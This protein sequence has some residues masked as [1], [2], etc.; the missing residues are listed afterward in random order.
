MN[1]DKTIEKAVKIAIK[2]YDKEK[3]SIEMKKVFHNT[4]LLMKHYNDLKLHIDN[5]VSDLHEIDQDI[6]APMDYYEDDEL[7]ILSIRKSKIKTLIMIS[8]IDAALDVLYKNE[9]R[10]GTVEKYLA[11]KK[12]FVDKKTYECIAEELNCS[13]ITVRRWV[14]EMLKQLGIYL[15]GVES[16]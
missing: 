6:L 3:K 15:F 4:K 10:N 2:E 8:H 11:L 5:A 1:I 13:I 7:Y 16:I 12:L 9:V 14:N